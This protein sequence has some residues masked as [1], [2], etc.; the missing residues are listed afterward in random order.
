MIRL[1]VA[2]LP[3]VRYPFFVQPSGLRTIIFPCIFPSSI[4]GLL[5]PPPFVHLHWLLTDSTTI[6][7][8]PFRAVF[9]PRLSRAGRCTELPALISAPGTTTG[10]SPISSRRFERIVP[11]VTADSVIA[12]SS[13]S[14]HLFR[15]NG[16][17][18]SCCLHSSR[19]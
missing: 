1:G 13:F 6:V 4:A 2:P 7:C 16:L 18:L 19:V 10:I 8:G 3:S 9:T 5:G 14:P 17:C 15:F 11:V 12:V